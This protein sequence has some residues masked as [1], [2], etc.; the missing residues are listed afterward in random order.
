MDTNFIKNTLL[1]LNLMIEREKENPSPK[2]KEYDPADDWDLINSKFNID[3]DIFNKIISKF[4]DK[5]IIESHFSSF[6][7]LY[8]DDGG[9]L[10][11]QNGNQAKSDEFLILYQ[12]KDLRKAQSYKK[13]LEKSLTSEEIKRIENKST[14][15]ELPIL[16]EAGE[17]NLRQDGLICYKNKVIDMRT[18]LKT[19]CELFISRPN[20]LINRDDIFDSLGVNTKKKKDTIS[21][22][23]S[24]LNKAL[25]PHFKRQPII[26]HKKEGWIFKP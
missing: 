4:I 12:M 3:A 2:N 11:D 17:L 20:E 8:A 19:L 23:V 26:N 22:Y 5:K 6:I 25:E 21:K 1:I 15:S 24:A 10:Y 13:E 14:L 18:G 7:P 9:F 16:Q